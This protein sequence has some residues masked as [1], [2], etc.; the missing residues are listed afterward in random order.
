MN[1]SAN[2]TES[3]DGNNV[4]LASSPST[5]TLRKYKI[6]KVKQTPTVNID[7]KTNLSYISLKPRPTEKIYG[8][9]NFANHYKEEKKLGQ[10]TFGAVYKGIHLETQ[11]CVAMKKILINVDNDLFP[12]TAQREITILKKLNHKN[13]IKLLEMVY[14]LPPDSLNNQ[15]SDDNNRS[16][17]FFYMILPYMVSDLAGILHNPRINL[18]MA[19]IKNITLQV[20]EGINYI[21]C[22]KYMH[23]DI[24][25]ANIL[26]DHN[27]TVKIADFGLARL[28]YGSPPNLTYPG[29]AGTGAKYTSVVVTR[30]YRA[31]ELVLGDKYYTTA[32]DIWGIGCV[33]GEFFEK[34]PILPGTSDIDQG[35]VIFKLLGTPTGEDWK[36]A[37]YLPGAE[38]TRSKYKRTLNE[39]FGKFLNETGLNFMSKLLHLDPLQRYTAM[40]AMNDPFFKEDPLP[41]ERLN[42][43]CEESHESDIKRYKEEMHQAMSQR[44]PNAPQGHIFE[45]PG[46]TNTSFSRYPS[47][48]DSASK[49]DN[50]S[51]LR[52][53]PAGPAKKH[54]SANPVGASHKSA[55]APVS[56]YGNNQSTAHIPPGIATYG[57]NVGQHNRYYR[58]NQNAEDYYGNVSASQPNTRYNSHPTN[59]QAPPG[60]RDTSHSS[61]YHNPK[62]NTSHASTSVTTSYQRQSTLPQV[63]RYEGNQRDLSKKESKNSSATAQVPDKA[64]TKTSKRESRP[65]ET[66][67]ENSRH[68]D[69]DKK[70]GDFADLY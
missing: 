19:E 15:G 37:S 35:H 29:G 8:V 11:R 20:L 9:T 54:P 57:K 70:S 65:E 46:K 30:W 24:K 10:G 59:Y 58:R 25:T 55:N 3:V 36:L 14:D 28:Y 16:N 2:A 68:H 31:P 60:Q 32:V 67:N 22:S 17:K 6:G 38:L 51:F 7:P 47:N 4:S 45:T 5:G 34:K 50:K 56:R 42:L 33:F 63:S 49:R 23:R 1:G 39:R 26:I 44:A 40:A 48:L 62:Y 69:I 66:S 13:I 41:C 64:N 52:Q 53:P 21:H 18:T 12:I 27:G 43:P 61:N